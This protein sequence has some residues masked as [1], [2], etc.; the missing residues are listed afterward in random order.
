MKNCVHALTFHDYHVMF[1]HSYRPEISVIR[2]LLLLPFLG[3]GINYEYA[4]YFSKN[5]LKPKTID[6]ILPKMACVTTH[7]F[8][9]CGYCYWPV[10]K[11]EL[12]FLFT[13]ASVFQPFSFETF[14]TLIW[15]CCMDL[16]A[17]RI[18]R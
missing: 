7:L 14:C 15:K 4:R 2:Y 11:N 6:S 16:E 1:N 18:H 13:E 17:R 9:T 3:V 5:Q 8:L 10:I 12:I